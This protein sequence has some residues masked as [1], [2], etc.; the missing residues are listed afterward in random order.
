MFLAHTGRMTAEAEPV[1]EIWDSH[2]STAGQTMPISTRPNGYCGRLSRSKASRSRGPTW[3]C[4]PAIAPSRTWA[5][6]HSGSEAAG[7]TSGNPKRTSTGVRKTNGSRMRRGTGG[8]KRTLKKR[9]SHL[10][11]DWA[12]FRWGWFKWTPKARAVYC[13]TLPHLRMTSE[14][15]SAGW[16]WTTKKPWPW[17]AAGTPSARHTGLLVIHMWVQTP[18]VLMWICKGSAGLT[19]FRQ[20][21]A[22]TPSHPVLKEPGPRIRPHGPMG[23]SRTYSIT[24]GSSRNHPQEQCSIDLR[25]KVN[26]TYPMPMTVVKNHT[27]S[28]LLQTWQWSLIPN[29]IK[30]LNVSMK[31]M[32]SLVMRLQEH[33]SNWHT[34]TWDL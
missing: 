10:K 33:G 1:E 4:S 30:F 21:K 18:R 7:L 12:R 8:L 6:N 16:A 20:A 11:A 5:S 19:L 15:R 3:W 28:C 24:N 17:S 32:K 34:G 14:S 23:N 27:L 31:T 2:H 29:N 25:I 22:K 26:W 13:M 9:E